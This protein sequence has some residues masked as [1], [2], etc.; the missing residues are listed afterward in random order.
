MGVTN[1][2]GPK[3]KKSCLKCSKSFQSAGI[4]NRICRYCKA[5]SDW[6]EPSGIPVDISTDIHEVTVTQQN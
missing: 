2:T 4:E 5:R 3:I 1:A 6:S